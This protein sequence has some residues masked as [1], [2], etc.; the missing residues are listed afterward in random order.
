[1]LAPQEND[2]C[3]IGLDITAVIGCS[4]WCAAGPLSPCPCCLVLQ[5]SKG[6]ARPGVRY[7]G[8]LELVRAPGS[9][10]IEGF[11]RAGKVP[12]VCFDIIPTISLLEVWGSGVR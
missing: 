2:P 5:T 3:I 12:E 11:C 8:A 4:P 6:F 1:M 10:D 9:L 7:Q